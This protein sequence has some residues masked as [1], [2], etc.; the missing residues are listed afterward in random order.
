MRAR[1][2]RHEDDGCQ[3]ISFGGFGDQGAGSQGLVV[4]MGG[5]DEPARLSPG[6]GGQTTSA[7]H[8]RSPSPQTS[9]SSHA[10]AAWS[11]A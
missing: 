3:A 11:R 2:V 8:S 9:R 1:S 7:Y 10:I 4:G 6:R 5:Q